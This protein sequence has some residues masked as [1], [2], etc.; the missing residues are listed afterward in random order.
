MKKKN[1]A[2]K[3]LAPALLGAI[4]SLVA[5][6][7]V[8]YAWFTM[9]NT[10]EVGNIDVNVQAADG[11]QVS[12]DAENWK[13]VISLAELNGVTSNVI[14]SDKFSPIS[15]V[16]T[17]TDGVQKMFLGNVESNGKITATETTGN[18][19]MFDL[20]VKVDVDS[21]LYL[22]IGSSVVDGTE[23][24]NTHLAARVSFSDLGNVAY[25]ANYSAETAK[26]L[27]ASTTAVIWEPN[28][29]LHTASAI[30]S[31]KATSGAAI[32]T[33]KGVNAVITEPNDIKD[34][35]TGAVTKTYDSHFSDVT[36][37]QPAYDS[38]LATSAK[39]EL[40]SLE[41]GV[42]KVRIYIWLEGQD[43]DCANDIAKGSFV[44]KLK[45]TKTAPEQTGE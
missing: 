32:A 17:V 41:A 12:V 14:S 23:G 42:N 38:N 1:Y 37:K 45:F 19:Q 7:S 24:K 10:A 8:S 4:C 30:A 44:T 31:G 6:T 22:D 29:K 34:A 13:S 43:V 33:Y 39:Q 26:A 18:Y 2:K 20:Y 36:P 25:D 3:A 27:K 16:G 9:G 21:T 28:A 15:S 11:M 35:E 40:L 5:L